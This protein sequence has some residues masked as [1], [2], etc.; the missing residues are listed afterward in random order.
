MQDE[1]RQRLA[2][3]VQTRR[4]ELGL[5]IR[6]AAD[7]SGIARGTWTALED[8]SRRTTDNNYAAIETVLEWAPG[9]ITRT[10]AGGHPTPVTPGEHALDDEV[11]VK[12]MQSNIP[13]RQKHRIVQMLI[14]EQENSRQQLARRAAELVDLASAASDQL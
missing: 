4:Q 14:A 11:L 3:A 5:S 6:S 13:D 12:V 7:A 8:G 9:S 2:Q 1:E 10:L